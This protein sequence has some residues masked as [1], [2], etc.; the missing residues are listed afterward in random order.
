VIY[1]FC[2]GGLAASY[3]FGFFGFSAYA[4]ER[5]ALKRRKVIT[6]ES[7]DTATMERKI[8]GISPDIIPLTPPCTDYHLRNPGGA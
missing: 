1:K 6:T 5:A 7:D 4:R 3:E 8:G 2:L